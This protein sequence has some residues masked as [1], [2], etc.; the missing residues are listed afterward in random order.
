LPSLA[1]FKLSTFQIAASSP[2][3]VSQETRLQEKRELH[4]DLFSLFRF[5]LVNTLA[6]NVSI[7]AERIVGTTFKIRNERESERANSDVPEL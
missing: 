3:I 4:Y 6:Q 7:N 1:I 5:A 2:A